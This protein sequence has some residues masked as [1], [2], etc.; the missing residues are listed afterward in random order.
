MTNRNENVKNPYTQR[1]SDRYQDKNPTL[2]ACHLGEQ[3]TLNQWVLGSSPRWCTKDSSASM[4]GCFLYACNQIK[5]SLKCTIGDENSTAAKGGKKQSSGLFFSARESAREPENL[6]ACAGAE[7]DSPVKQG[8]KRRIFCCTIPFGTA[9][10]F[11]L[12][13]AFSSRGKKK[14]CILTILIQRKIWGKSPLKSEG[15]IR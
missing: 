3:L 7:T 12:R 10:R 6:C 15:K 5:R 13:L 11:A 8:S 9:S 1:I 14:F 2:S 4:Q